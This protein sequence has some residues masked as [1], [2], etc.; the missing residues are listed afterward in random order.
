MTRII[1]PPKSRRRRWT[2]LWSLCVVLGV[3]MFFISGAQAVHELGVFELDTGTHTLGVN[4]YD[5]ANA[6]DEA[7]AG[8]DWDNVCYQKA[9]TSLAN[10]GYG[11]SA[12]DAQTNCGVNS[13][14]T[15][16]TAVAWTADS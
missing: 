4:P 13:G 15:N 3:G 5:G 12:A 9:T 14:T 16:A 6:T 11:L 1:G 10:G 7:A 8:N 2:F